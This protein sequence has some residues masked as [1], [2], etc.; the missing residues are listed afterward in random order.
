LGRLWVVS[1]LHKGSALRPRRVR[2]K[3]VSQ[4]HSP[5]PGKP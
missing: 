4:G 2:A 5:K 1:Q 3:I